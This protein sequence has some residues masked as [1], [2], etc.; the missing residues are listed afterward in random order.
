MSAL[1]T[2]SEFLDLPVPE[3]SAW[4]LAEDHYLVYTDETRFVLQVDGDDPSKVQSLVPQSI[5]MF[6]PIFDDDEIVCDARSVFFKLLKNPT[7]TAS[8]YLASMS[9]AMKERCDAI[10]AKGRLKD[11]SQTKKSGVRR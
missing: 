5:G 8:T 1:S 10:I 7:T 6:D 3:F 11:E 9:K 4:E 2:I